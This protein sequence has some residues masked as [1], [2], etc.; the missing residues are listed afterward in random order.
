MTHYESPGLMRRDHQRV[1]RILDL[2]TDV[3]QASAVAI[4]AALRIDRCLPFELVSR[5][6]ISR[7]LERLLKPSW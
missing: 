7:S 3:L 6:P 1:D 2:C 4:I 5:R